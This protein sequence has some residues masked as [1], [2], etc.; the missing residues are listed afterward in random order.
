MEDATAV[1]RVSN[2]G[3]GIPAADLPHVFERFYRGAGRAADASGV[4]LG[5][6]ICRAVTEAYGGRI[7]AESSPER[8]TTI[9][10]RLPLARAS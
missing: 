4:G 8:G 1:L 9:T 2:T 7:A 5:L 6:A 10:V 3:P